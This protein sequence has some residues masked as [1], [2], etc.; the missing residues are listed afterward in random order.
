MSTIARPQ[1]LSAEE[2]QLLPEPK[3]GSRQ[4][5]V[6]GVVVTMPPPGVLHGVCCLKVGRVLG[7]FIDDHDLGVIASNDAGFISDRDPD[8]V[9]GPDLSFWSKSRIAEIPSGYSRLAPDLAV[10]VVSP[11][12]VFSKVQEKVRH[13]LDHGVRLVWLVNPEDRSVTV[14][15]SK[16]EMQILFDDDDID[17]NDVL[18]GFRCKVA[19]LFPK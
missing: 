13:Y 4:E 3:D 15:K 6:R 19:D 11:S 5:L 10:E 17:G 7:N 12:D 2:F 16:R 1:L 9:R 18:S 14:C 8:T